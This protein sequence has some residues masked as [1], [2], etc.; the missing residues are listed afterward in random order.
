MRTVKARGSRPVRTRIGSRS[1]YHMC[2]HVC[3]Y[4]WHQDGLTYS[5]FGI[6]YSGDDT[7]S[8]VARDELATAARLTHLG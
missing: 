5:V 2:G 4:E 3:G 6:Y 8:I 7:G 1:V